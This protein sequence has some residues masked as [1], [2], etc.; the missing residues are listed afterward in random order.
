ME[1]L[2]IL[3]VFSTA[4]QGKVHCFIT[5]ILTVLQVIKFL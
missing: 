5:H 3:L 1:G 4:Y 2:W